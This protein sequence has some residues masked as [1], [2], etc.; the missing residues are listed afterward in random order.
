MACSNSLS[1]K[2]ISFK[3]LCLISLCFIYPSSGIFSQ[4][5]ITPENNSFNGRFFR[6]NLPVE[7]NQ[8]ATYFSQDRKGFIWIGTYQRLFRFDGTEF[9]EAGKSKFDDSTGFAGKMVSSIAEDDQGKIWFGTS[10]GLNC[11]DPSTGWF[12]N[13]CPDKS[14]ISGNNNK[15]QE[16]LISKDGTIWIASLKDIFS[17]DPELKTFTKYPLDNKAMMIE[18][19]PLFRSQGRILEDLSGNIWFASSNG[20][21]MFDKIRSKLITFHSIQNDPTSLSSNN[22][23]C[24]SMDGS[25]NIWISTSDNGLNRVIDAG[26]GIFK[27]ISLPVEKG[28][29]GQLDSISVIL[30]DRDE[31]SIWVFGNQ[32]FGKYSLSR[33]EFSYYKYP[34]PSKIEGLKRAADKLTFQFAFNNGPDEIIAVSEGPGIVLKFN[35]RDETAI[36]YAVP[37]YSVFHS[38]I[39]SDGAIWFSCPYDWIFQLV[40]KPLSY[41]YISLPHNSHRKSY[42]QQRIVQDNSGKI[43]FTLSTGIL[44]S[45]NPDINKYFRM[46]PYKFPDKSEKASSVYSDSEGKLWFTR[47]DGKIAQIDPLNG[48]MKLYPYSEIYPGE[49]KIIKEDKYHN[50]WMSGK[51]VF[52]RLDSGSGK[53][54]RYNF[55]G[56]EFN[57]ILRDEDIYD[58]CVDNRN[59]LWFGLRSNKLL[60]CDLNSNTVN[61]VTI[62]ENMNLK[63][64][65]LCIRIIMDSK[66]D[67][68]FLYTTEG[69]FFIDNET[70]KLSHIEFSSGTEINGYLDLFSDNKNRLWIAHLNG[71][72]IFNPESGET[73]SLKINLADYNVFS[74]QLNNGDVLVHNEEKL[75]LIEDSLRYNSVPPEVFVTSV[76]INNKDY[77][78]IYNTGKDIS[79]INK[80]ELKSYENNIRIDFS[81]LSFPEAAFGSYKY[82]MKGIDADTINTGSS[83]RFAEYKKLKTGKYIFWVTAS[84]NDGIWNKYGRTIEINILPPWYDTQL[85]YFI[86]IILFALLIYLFVSIRLGGLKREKKKLEDEVK[87]RTTELEVKNKQ[88]LELDRLK[89]RFFTE[90]S[91]EIRTPLSLISGPIENLIREYDKIDEEKRIRWMEMIRRN[92]RRLLKLVNQ[93]LDISRLDAGK[94]KI[95][96]IESDVLNSLRILAH[97]YLSLAESRK[98]RYRI[99][100]PPSGFITLF[101]MDKTE[102]ILSNLLSNAFKFTPAFGAVSC[103]ISI[104]KKADSKTSAILN[105]SVRDTGIGIGSD[106]IEKIFDRFYRIEG[107]WEKDGTGTGIGLSLT[108]E[109]VNL[110]HGT[111]KVS[112]EPGLGS[113]FEVELPLGKDHLKSD[114]YIILDIREGDPDN[115]NLLHEQ[116]FATE[117]KELIQ[118]EKELSV[119]IIEDNSD[120]RKYLGDNLSQD[121]HVHNADNGKT[122]L[123][124]AVSKIP[125][126]IITDRILPDMDGLEVCSILKNDERTSHIPVIMCTAKT[127][128]EEKIEGLKSGA[129][130]YIFKPFDIKE[131]KV[132]ISNLIVS[133]E[134]LRMKY[135]ML[136]GLEFTDKLS[137]SMDDN[138]MARVA[139]IITENIR[140][141]DFD[142]GAL[143]EKTGMSRVH[144][145]RKIKAITGLSPSALI[146]NFRMK[147]AAELIKMKSMSLTKIALNVGFTNPS[148]FSK[149][150][151]D[152]YGVSPK[153]YSD[154]NNLKR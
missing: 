34:A 64:G 148:Y 1:R 94:M 4:K 33:R 20:L 73:R 149:C 66:G 124:S 117:E 35:K 80:I 57:K 102:K 87:Q 131:L 26:N 72:L 27:K 97:E 71:I 101:D 63:Y 23:S 55:Q 133:R 54:N 89:T 98:I 43:W 147:N 22:V 129:D 52:L 28:K 123:A 49:I 48:R 30:A 13:Y 21:H 75:F 2:F 38:I 86:Y 40:L 3:I 76:R 8:T 122:G 60:Y 51:G 36:V 143:Q 68:Y 127:T 74:Y 7:G 103:H 125:D 37:N 142:V 44:T 144:L 113:L 32:I 61:S 119:L 154:N 12:K 100:I 39:D 135:G 62:P 83:V 108:N 45:E 139:T 99:D 82:I 69:L 150:F 77:N 88:I 84:N 140:D 145:Y 116:Y 90:I 95:T 134:K 96:L 25:G 17:F 29:F 47:S 5:F 107:Q 6:Y 85:A 31:G 18:E 136:T 92:S 53:I 138:F 19:I 46:K 81:G 152:Y 41:N 126:I 56:D 118:G 42:N 104:L 109:F 10:G 151:R 110:L 128:L 24:I 105:I 91:H 106:N 59:R 114:E 58:F 112:S 93:L 78:R 153:E 146:R 14:D 121:Y 130:E 137:M 111:I 50:I 11:Y 132:R 65:D 120:L 67:L 16:M 15:V 9:I 115:N 141:F 79:G 70:L